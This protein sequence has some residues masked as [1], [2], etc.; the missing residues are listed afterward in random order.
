MHH[1]VPERRYTEL[2]FRSTFV[3]SGHYGSHWLGDNF[4]RWADLRASIIGVMEF[5]MFGIPYTGADICGFIDNTNEELCLRWHQLGAFYPFSRNHNSQGNIDQDPSV[6]PS[7]A[8][9]A[10]EAL[11]FRYYYLPYLYR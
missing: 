9:A 5:N 6:W 3:S 10:R 4:A 8:R 7:V 1:Q 11:L 2:I